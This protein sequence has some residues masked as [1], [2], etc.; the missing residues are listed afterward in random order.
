MEVVDSFLNP[1]LEQAVE[2]QKKDKA[3]GLWKDVDAEEVGDDVTFLD[4]L[5]RCTTGQQDVIAL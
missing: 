5:V 1:I 4:H 3:A 2:N